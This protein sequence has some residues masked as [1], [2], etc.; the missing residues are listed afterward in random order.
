[1]NIGEV[2]DQLTG[3]SEEKLYDVFDIHANRQMNN[4]C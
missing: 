3:Q 2:H 1:M 4:D